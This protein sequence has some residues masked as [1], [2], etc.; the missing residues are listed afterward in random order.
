MPYKF[1][2]DKR[3]GHLSTLICSGQIARQE[4][5]T[6]I[7]R[8]PYPSKEMLEQDKVYV[9]KKLSLAEEDFDKI[10][11]QPRRNYK[12]FPN[13]EVWFKRFSLIVKY[14]KKKATYN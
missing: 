1:N 7:A 10:M 13:N 9:L 11:H 2:I 5:L 14:A 8:D 6:Q 4:A 3:R 12:D